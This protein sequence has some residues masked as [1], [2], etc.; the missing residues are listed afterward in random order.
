MLGMPKTGIDPYKMK[1]CRHWETLGRC[2]LGSD[3]IQPLSHGDHCNFAHG[4][5]ELQRPGSTPAWWKESKGKGKQ[6]EVGAFGKDWE[7]FLL[8][9]IGFR[10]GFVVFHVSSLK[11]HVFPANS[12]RYPCNFY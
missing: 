3:S 10:G 2:P 11:R 4:E 9:S 8:I 7:G 5:N 12:Y 6:D 1:P